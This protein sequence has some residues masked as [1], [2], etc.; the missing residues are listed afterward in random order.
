MTQ[1]IEKV[2]LLKEKLEQQL[3]DEAE[4]VLSEISEI[5]NPSII[6]LLVPLFNDEYPYDEIMYSIVHAIECF[7]DEVYAERILRTIP[8]FIYHS[9][10]WA[11]IVHIRILNSDTTRLL[12]IKECSMNAS[13]EQ[14]MALKKLLTKIN[15]VDAG[16][17]VRTIPLMGVL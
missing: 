1:L 14:K 4:R 8:D 16:F 3:I 13:D 17:M 10:R 12:Y 11:S 2:S 9:P 5:E 6:E 15:E 7:E